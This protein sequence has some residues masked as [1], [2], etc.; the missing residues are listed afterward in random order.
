MKTS[1]A[2]LGKVAL[3]GIFIGFIACSG[4]ERP[5]GN[6]EISASVS[7][8]GAFTSSK[9]FD[10]V[11]GTKVV[12]TATILQIQGTDN[13]GR[14]FVLRISTYDG[15]G[16]YEM[17]VDSTGNLAIWINGPTAGDQYSTGFEGTSGSI[18]VAEEAEG[19]VDGS[20]AFTGKLS[21]TSAAK[22]ITNGKFKVNLQ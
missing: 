19:V 11:F 3:F 1:V 22:T 16:T 6:E 21:D 2:T 15:P 7:G 8:V 4:D 10:T 18:V 5:T 12:T 17:G 13:S 14:G 9:D 20:F